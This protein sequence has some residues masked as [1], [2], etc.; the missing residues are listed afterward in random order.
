MNKLITISF[1]L[2]V[3]LFFAST[4]IAKPTNIVLQTS[5]HISVPIEVEDYARLLDGSISQLTTTRYIIRRRPE[6]IDHPH[7][8]PPQQPQIHSHVN[9]RILYLDVY[10]LQGRLLGTR[11]HNQLLHLNN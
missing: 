6:A 5:N 2:T 4:A 1:A 8:Q 9:T 7:E 10:N 3:S 11:V